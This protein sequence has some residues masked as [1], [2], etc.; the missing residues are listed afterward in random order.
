MPS[1]LVRDFGSLFRDNNP[2]KKPGAVFGSDSPPEAEE[3]QAAIRTNGVVLIRN[4][5]T[6]P[7]TF[8]DFTNRIGSNFGVHHKIKTGGRARALKDDAT[9]CTVETG[10]TALPWHREKAYV[11]NPPDLLHFWCQKSV[12]NSGMTGLCD[13]EAIYQALPEKAQKYFD[14]FTLTFGTNWSLETCLKYLGVDTVEEA[15]AV[16]RHESGRLQPGTELDYDLTPDN[17]HFSYRCP[18]IQISKWSGKP[19][20]ANYALAQPHDDADPRMLKLA[21]KAAK[22]R[23][24]FQ[25]WREGDLIIIDNTRFLHCRSDFAEFESEDRVILFRMSAA[26]F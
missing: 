2:F 15:E 14:N 3:I 6:S 10:N 21:Q 1:M 4:V 17:Y 23:G 9:V 13:G 11:R 12:P 16:L 20:F 8:V 5:V 22:R 25:S 18:S 19:A 24:F 26:D 7:Q